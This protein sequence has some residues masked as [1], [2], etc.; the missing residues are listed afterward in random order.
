V[1]ACASATAV[2][3][4]CL[5]HGAFASSWR[6]Q[7]HQKCHRTSAAAAAAAAAAT[8]HAKGVALSPAHALGSRSGGVQSWLVQPGHRPGESTHKEQT[9]VRAGSGPGGSGLRFRR[10]RAYECAGTLAGTAPGVPHQG[11]Q[12]GLLNTAGKGQPLRS[13]P[14]RAGPSLPAQEH[15]RRVKQPAAAQAV[16]GRIRQQQARHE[17]RRTH[18]NGRINREGLRMGPPGAAA[19]TQHRSCSS[20]GAAAPCGTRG[21]WSK[22]GSRGCD[23]PEQPPRLAARRA[24]ARRARP[25]WWCSTLE[26]SP[27]RQQCV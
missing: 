1:P 19:R 8:T 12:T 26:Y 16:N 10:T 13:A 6:L 7:A 17:G 4:K 20:H 22:R 23:P 11:E 25:L 9:P 14:H 27:S 18:A 3:A 15:G 21:L 2:T 5:E 24:T